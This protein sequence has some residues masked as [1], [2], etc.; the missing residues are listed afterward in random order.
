[1]SD[2]LLPMPG[3]WTRGLA[4]AAHPDDMEFGAAGAVVAWTT[5]GKT[6]SYLLV[7][8]GEAGIDDLPPAEAAKVRE[9]EQRASAAIAGVAEVEFLDYP[10]GVIEYGVRLRRDLAAAIRRYRPE[11]L[12]GFNHRE[13]TFTGKRNSPD[14]RNTGRA[15]LDAVGDA[16]NR[17]IFPG[18]GEAAAEPWRVR[19]VAIAG[20]PQPT[21]AVDIS[22]T[23]DTA[24]ASVEAHAAYLRA[25]G[26]PPGG[27][28][29][30][31][32]AFA[33]A[34]GKRFG[35]RPAISFELIP[36]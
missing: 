35:G 19:H 9:Q 18:P 17:W 23:V 5:A 33:A 30:P 36:A 34:T 29:G 15:L 13:L 26:V 31:L 11:M 14:H 16:A 20:S 4:V 21:H 27:A 24:V 1:M 10:D 3:D 25:L 2:D 28:R 12:I 7:S 22:A 8:R 32:E 6:M